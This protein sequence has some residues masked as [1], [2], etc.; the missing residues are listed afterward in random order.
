[1][2]EAVLMMRIGE[3]DLK[4]ALFVD[5]C[6][7]MQRAAR[8]RA[9]TGS[10]AKANNNDV[11]VQLDS[12]HHNFNSV[13]PTDAAGTLRLTSLNR[14]NM[15]D[16]VAEMDPAQ[17]PAAYGEFANGWGAMSSIIGLARWKTMRVRH[18]AA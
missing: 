14:V 3:N 7:W 18:G 15:T 16:T 8:L 13:K 6:R 9:T 11:V 12:D 4:A 17:R 10:A 1:M 2:A 5:A